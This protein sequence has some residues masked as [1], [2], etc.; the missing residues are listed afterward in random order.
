MSEEQLP[1]SAIVHDAAAH[2]FW[3]MAE[4]LGVQETT[5]AVIESS[6]YCLMQ[7]IFTSEV[8]SKYNFHNLPKEDRN[9]FCKAIATEAEEFSIKRQNM[10]GIIYG[11]DAEAGRSP[12]AQYVNTA[13]LEVLP[14]SI[15]ALGENIEKIGRLCIR[16]P[17]PAVVFSDECPPQDIIQV[18]CTSDALGFQYPIF[19]GHISTQQLTD[20]LFASSGI[21]FI[22]APNGEI[23]KK[24]SQVIQNS[25]RFFKETLFNREFGTSTLRVDW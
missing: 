9:L 5:E 8:L 15:T 11:D 21:F 6:G 12:S 18:A 7:Q 16:H 19:L 24:W 13:D 17:L 2:L 3:M 22:P 23:G 1:I 20:G 4:I 25:G 10:E 14:R